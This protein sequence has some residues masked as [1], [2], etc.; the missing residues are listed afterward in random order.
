MFCSPSS[1]CSA[2]QAPS[3]YRQPHHEDHATTMRF[4]PAKS[5]RLHLV[6]VEVGQRQLRRLRANRR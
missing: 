5:L 4:C 3:S 6:A 2:C 1:S